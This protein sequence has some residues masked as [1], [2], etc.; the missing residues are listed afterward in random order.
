MENLFEEFTLGSAKLANRFL[1]PP[2]KLGYGNPDGT[3]TDR[4][5]LFYQ[6]IS[7]QGPAVAIL[8]P[9]SVTPEGR[10]HPRQPGIPHRDHR[11][12]P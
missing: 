1:F 7:K 8:E 3:V 2:I 11:G 4:Q 12:C 6:Q 5:L 10:E 9:V